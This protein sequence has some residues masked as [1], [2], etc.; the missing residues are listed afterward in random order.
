MG[1]IFR[2]TRECFENQL[3]FTSDFSNPYSREFRFLSILAKISYAAHLFDPNLVIHAVGGFIRSILMRS[4]IYDLD[5]RTFFINTPYSPED[6]LN[7]LINTKF[8]Q[9][10]LK[11]NIES[12]SIYTISIENTIIS[13]R[14]LLS[15][16]YKA[17][18]TANALSLAIVWKNSTPCQVSLNIPKISNRFVNSIQK[19][20]VP[21]YE[22]YP[23]F[24]CIQYLQ[25]SSVKT[26]IGQLVCSISHN[27]KL[28]VNQA[29]IKLLSFSLSDDI[30]QLMDDNLTK[31]II[32]ILVL[33]SDVKIIFKSLLRYDQAQFYFPEWMKRLFTDKVTDLLQLAALVYSGN[34]KFK[35]LVLL[36]F[37]NY[38]FRNIESNN[39][40]GLSQFLSLTR[41]VIQGTSTVGIPAKSNFSMVLSKSQTSP[42]LAELY[43]NLM[44]GLTKKHAHTTALDIL[45]LLS[46]LTQ[47][48][49]LFHQIYIPAHPDNQTQLFLIKQKLLSLFK[50]QLQKVSEIFHHEINIEKIFQPLESKSFDYRPQDLEQIICQNWCNYQQK[51]Q[52]PYSFRFLSQPSS[53]L[54]CIQQVGSCLIS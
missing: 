20:I 42:D 19:A 27:S 22:L 3:N 23:D 18:A 4:E 51:I 14:F 38:L 46:T 33:I 30:D 43:K 53:T 39:C 12:E 52:L 45:L 7:Y 21:E 10:F 29:I 1:E 2:L 41:Q 48:N 25:N 35:N 44:K 34:N 36:C 37:H 49:D 6:L 9:S 54:T 5:L 47:L 50:T 17:D 15:E 28:N 11:C 24:C 26:Q 40:L 32:S 8:I 31:I 16:N 13:L